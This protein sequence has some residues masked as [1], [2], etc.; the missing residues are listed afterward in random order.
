LLVSAT[1]APLRVPGSDGLVHLEYDLLV[2][3]AFAAPA[4][5][6]SIEVM[7]T[8]GRELLRLSGEALAAVTEPLLKTAEAKPTGSP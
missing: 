4:T 3:N 6:T 8:D 1:N 2:T 5:L 7:T